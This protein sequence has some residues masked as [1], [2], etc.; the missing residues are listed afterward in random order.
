[1]DPLQVIANRIGYLNS[2]LPKDSLEN[3]NE[4]NIVDS[5]ASAHSLIESAVSGRDKLSEVIRRA[6]EVE[7]FL[8]PNFIAENRQT[9][10]KEI[11]LNTVVNDVAQS[12]ELLQKIRDLEPVMGA[13]YFSSIPDVTAQLKALI[14][15]AREQKE[16]ND[17]IEESLISSIHR[18]AEIQN[19][20]HRKLQDMND[21]LDQYEENAERKKQ[22]KS[23]EPIDD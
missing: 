7:R 10:L 16:R 20:I 11:Y 5:I 23:N 14:G 6:D 19:E 17:M 3:L 15:T 2:I 8:D 13:E 22:L 1:M 18:Y 12:F 21:F 4:A 9:N